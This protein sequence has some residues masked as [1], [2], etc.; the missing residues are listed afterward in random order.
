MWIFNF[1]F[2]YSCH[3][4]RHLAYALSCTYLWK[5]SADKHILFIYS[6]N[7]I[8]LDDFHIPDFS[9]HMT[10]KLNNHGELALG[11]SS[12]HHAMKN[13]ALFSFASTVTKRLQE[14]SLF[15]K[16]MSC[17]VLHCSVKVSMSIGLQT[18]FLLIRRGWWHPST[19][20]KV[21]YT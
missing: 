7:L 20:T 4:V 5:I 2:F 1:F 17:L 14:K 13:T 16:I 10:E 21:R 18:H 9:W 8:L 6:V 3:L 15:L 12:N 11:S 19:L